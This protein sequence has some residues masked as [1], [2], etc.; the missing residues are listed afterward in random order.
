MTCTFSCC[1][2]VWLFASLRLLY[3]GMMAH[4]DLDKLQCVCVCVCMRVCVKAGFSKHLVHMHS[5]F[6]KE[7]FSLN[8]SNKKNKKTSTNCPKY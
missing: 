7:N 8:R 2:T 1:L 4:V 6:L 5:Y 3:T